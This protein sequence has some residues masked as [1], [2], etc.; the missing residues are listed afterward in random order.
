MMSWESFCGPM[1]GSRERAMP[2]AMTQAG[3]GRRNGSIRILR[4][5]LGE[6][7]TTISYGYEAEGWKDQ[8]SLLLYPEPPGGCCRDPGQ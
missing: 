2:G 6:P 7:E 4:G 3:T 5:T 8:L 1:T